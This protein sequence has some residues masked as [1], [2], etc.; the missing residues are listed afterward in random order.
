MNE[1]HPPDDEDRC[2]TQVISRTK[3]VDELIETRR[4][5]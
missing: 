3:E 2:E 1:A 5:D 4:R